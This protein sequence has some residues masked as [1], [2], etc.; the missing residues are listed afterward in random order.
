M[1]SKMTGAAVTLGLFWPGLILGGA[2]VRHTHQAH[3]FC[4][5][6]FPLAL[7]C[8]NHVPMFAV[9]MHMHSLLIG[10]I[11]IAW[12]ILCGGMQIWE[13]ENTIR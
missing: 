7:L 3:V 10:S 4:M 12:G 1:G 11:A 5:A 9:C 6:L 13:S 8:K 2:V